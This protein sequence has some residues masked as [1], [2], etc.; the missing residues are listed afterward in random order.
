MLLCNV[1]DNVVVYNLRHVSVTFHDSYSCLLTYLAGG[2][3]AQ[4]WLRWHFP[5]P[6]VRSLLNT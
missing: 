6:P 1:N 5:C 3:V 4:S 2:S